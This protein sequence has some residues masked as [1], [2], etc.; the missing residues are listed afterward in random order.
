MMDLRKL[1]DKTGSIYIIIL[2]CK[3]ILYLDLLYFCVLQ[4]ILKISE[5][6]KTLHKVVKKVVGLFGGYVVKQ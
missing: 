1:C 6:W 3:W 2:R 5:L 4:H